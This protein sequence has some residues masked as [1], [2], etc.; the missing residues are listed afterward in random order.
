M[1]S[2]PLT[3]LVL[4]APVAFA[5]LD[6]YTITVTASRVTYVQPDQISIAVS[7]DTDLG[8]TF[9]QVLK[10]AQMAGVV[11]TD[12]SAVYAI[13]NNPSSSGS[14]SNGPPTGFEWVFF[15]NVP[16]ASLKDTL[17][18]LTK[19]RTA[20]AQQNPGTTLSFDIQGVQTSPQA[21]AAQTC[22][23]QDLMTDARAQAI[24]VSGAAGFGVGSVVALSDASSLPGIAYVGSAPAS[25]TLSRPGFMTLGSVIQD[26]LP[27]RCA[28]VVKFRLTQP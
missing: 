1:R 6:S 13:S 17:N 10:L 12:F 26:V 11:A 16:F 25:P 8:A 2:L 22:K 18:L 20:I 7:I 15:P 27:P 3:L 14:Y 21:L 19:A 23:A 24:A 4:C 5:Q 9:D 28:I